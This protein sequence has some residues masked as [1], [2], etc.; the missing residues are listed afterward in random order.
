M[1]PAKKKIGLVLSGGGAKGAYEAGVW[2]ALEQLG[3]T[4]YIDGIIGTSVGA[5]NA[6]LFDTCDT[7]TS[8]EIWVNLKESD[9]LHVDKGVLYLL[10]A[11]PL[12]YM[13]RSSVWG[14]MLGGV[15]SQ[16]RLEEILKQNVDFRKSRRSLY[17]VCTHTPNLSVSEVFCLAE[18]A[19][20]IRRKIVLASC[21]LPLIYKG[22]FGVRINGAGFLDGGL[23]DN[24]PRMKLRAQGWR[25]T[26]TVF[27]TDQPE[28]D[29][30]SS[31]RNI[32]IIPSESLG[33][34]V[35]GTLR[36]DPA[37]QKH[38]YELGIRDTLVLKDR[39]LKM[40]S[41]VE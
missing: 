24:T 41:A 21:A 25:Q 3:L 2:A 26:I 35:N 10:L 38:D 11:G 20:D 27:L 18:H 5:L 17:A 9:L 23:T 30:L 36:A 37:K 7:L 8:K 40:A 33:R 15:F 39:L 12:Y 28:P 32:D 6:V 4:G 29:K 13:V 34:F 16:K 19:P 1:N 14:L 31:D 22:F